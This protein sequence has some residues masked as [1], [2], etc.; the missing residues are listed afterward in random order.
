MKSFTLKTKDKVKKWETGVAVLLH[1]FCPCIWS[2]EFCPAFPWSSRRKTG[3]PFDWTYTIIY[4][5]KSYLNSRSQ[6]VFFDGKTSACLN[7]SHGVPQ[8]SVLTSILFVLYTADI[9]SIADHHGLPS[10]FYDNDFQIY[11]SCRQG[12]M[13]ANASFSIETEY[14]HKWNRRFDGIQ[15]T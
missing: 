8:G 4:W 2:R 11:L 10:H 9:S 7:I 5:I 13:P 1:G 12:T 6:T 3:L 14:M 15:Q